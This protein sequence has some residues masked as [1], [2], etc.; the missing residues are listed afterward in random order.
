MFPFMD[1]YIT[2]VYLGAWEGANFLYIIS[3]IVDSYFFC[4]G[5]PGLHTIFFFSVYNIII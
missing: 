2:Y 4:L 1:C 3:A 5:A